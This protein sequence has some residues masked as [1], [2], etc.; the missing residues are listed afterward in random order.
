MAARLLLA[1]PL[2]ELGRFYLPLTVA[3]AIAVPVLSLGVARLSS[4]PGLYERIAHGLVLA[5]MA[6][7]AVSILRHREET[8]TETD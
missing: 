8:E 5:W 6:A 7:V 1:R 2:Q 4:M 3:V